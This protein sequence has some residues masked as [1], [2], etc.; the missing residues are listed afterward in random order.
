MVETSEDSL[1][2]EVQELKRQLEE[3]KR[4]AAHPK[5]PHPSR[6]TLWLIGIVALAAVGGAFVLGNAPRKLRESVIAAEARDEEKAPP[7]VN[8][9]AATRAAG[10]SG[11]I[12]PG[13]IAAITEAPIVARSEGY[14]KKRYV[15]IGDHVKEGQ[16]LAEIEAPE[17]DHQVS[18]ANAQVRQAQAALEQATANYQQGKANEELAKV[19]AER[20]QRLAAKG[21]VSV[22][23]NDQYQA[24]Y[25]AQAANL[26]SL[27]K[28][29]S[30]ARS[31][32][33]SA[34]A[35]L[36]RLKELQS[37]QRVAA[38]FAGVVIARNVDVGALVN[39]NSTILF[40]LAQPNRLRVFVNVPQTH[41]ESMRVGRPARLR[42]DELPGRTFNAVITRTANS[43][44][45][46][47]R[48]IL[49]EVQL[50]NP[51]GLLFPG[52]YAQVDFG[53]TPAG[54]PLVI[55]GDALINRADGT[56]CA[57]V[58]PD[59]AVHFRKVT[60]GRDY[61]DRIEIQSGLDEGELV[62]MN[63]SDAVRENA[64]VN[65]VVTAIKPVK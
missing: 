62:V 6:V 41:V 10:G 17:L 58:G 49:V 26:N 18:Q 2:R 5:P 30:A 35:N 19:T 64:F 14:L 54:A 52:M 3:E 25:Q 16:L 29:V 1:R 47:T 9:T 27:D 15:D 7:L 34:Q 24:Q 56:L 11:L 33:T 23:E 31:S 20:W 42:V 43:L 53:V 50:D 32:I 40:R 60:V 51:Q 61:G 45:P 57:V 65:P 13:S 21:A 46:S 37:Y 38:P 36:S 8:V 12:L 55:P 4:K 22:Q 63:P 44:D 39:A 59:K 28:A 48:T